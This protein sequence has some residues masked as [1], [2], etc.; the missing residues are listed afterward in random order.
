MFDITYNSEKLP[1]GRYI[2]FEVIKYRGSPVYIDELIVI[3][4]SK[5]E[6]VFGDITGDGK[7][8]TDDLV[9]IRKMLL[10]IET[11]NES[12][13]LDKDDKITIIDFVILKKITLSVSL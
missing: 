7:I 5:V 6:P 4:N 3:G 11:G 10:G 1:Q 12:A 9:M 13:D 8:E 2:G